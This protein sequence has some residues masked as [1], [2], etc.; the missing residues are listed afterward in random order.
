MRCQ[1][2]PQPCP[3]TVGK[4]LVEGTGEPHGCFGDLGPCPLTADAVSM[5]TPTSLGP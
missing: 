1:S 3:K 4:S 2:E 5:R